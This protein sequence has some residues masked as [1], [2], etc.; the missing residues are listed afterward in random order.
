MIVRIYSKY[1]FLIIFLT[2]SFLL[3]CNKIQADTSNEGGV[4]SQMCKN[5]WTEMPKQQRKTY[6][7]Y[8]KFKPLCLE[9]VYAGKCN[10]GSVEL[11]TKLESLCRNRKGLDRTI[12]M[13]DG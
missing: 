7:S 9:A 12:K 10:D 6:G 11:G 1:T 13:P 2:L 4:Y 3:A 8:G 5:A